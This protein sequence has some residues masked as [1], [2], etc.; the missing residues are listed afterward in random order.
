MSVAGKGVLG[1]E[2]ERART[3]LVNLCDFSL[4]LGKVDLPT[5]RVSIAELG[6]RKIYTTQAK[7]ELEARGRGSKAR[8]VSLSR[9]RI[10]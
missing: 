6:A 8:V 9:N 5:S 7:P 2:P 10:K 3:A 1:Q 4:I